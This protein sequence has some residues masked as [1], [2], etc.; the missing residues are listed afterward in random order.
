MPD[1]KVFKRKYIN[2]LCDV[3]Q[4]RGRTSDQFPKFY[5]LPI[6]WTKEGPN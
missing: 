6:R 2:V 1:P 5:Y 3:G 4:D